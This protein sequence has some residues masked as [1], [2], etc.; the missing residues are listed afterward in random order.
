MLFEYSLFQVKHLRRFLMSFKP[1]SSPSCWNLS[2]LQPSESRSSQ[3]MFVSTGY[4]TIIAAEVSNYRIFD[5]IERRR[6]SDQGDEGQ[7][8]QKRI[9]TEEQE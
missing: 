9:P 1:T 8:D 2:A 6:I 3:H 4:C 7:Y 5:I